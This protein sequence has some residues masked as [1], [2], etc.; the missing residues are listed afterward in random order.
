MDEDEDET[1]VDW[2]ARVELEGLGIGRWK[3][4]EESY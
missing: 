4:E 1:M 2:R 3:D